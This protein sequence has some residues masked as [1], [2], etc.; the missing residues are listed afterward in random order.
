MRG[1]EKRV[2]YIL[3]RLTLIKSSV[4][5]HDVMHFDS[6]NS[7]LISWISFRTRLF[8]FPFIFLFLNSSTIRMHEKNFFVALCGSTLGQ[9]EKKEWGSLNPS[10]LKA[11]VT[12]LPTSKGPVNC[13]K[14]EIIYL[15][16][17][18]S[19]VNVNELSTWLLSEPWPWPHGQYIIR[20]QKKTDFCFIFGL[21]RLISDLQIVKLTL[22]Q[23]RG[24]AQ[25]STRPLALE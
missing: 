11:D 16:L 3:I 4:N 22:E 19:L 15:W 1:K 17:A 18:F 8:H 25:I 23:G 2:L 12:W 5:Q 6:L 10:Y 13:R 7:C 21:L 14:G 24:L 9:K 20:L